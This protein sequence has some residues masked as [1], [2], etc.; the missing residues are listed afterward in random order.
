MPRYEDEIKAAFTGMALD[1]L[2]IV[3]PHAEFLSWRPTPFK[4]K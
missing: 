4:Q 2:H 3:V 1:M